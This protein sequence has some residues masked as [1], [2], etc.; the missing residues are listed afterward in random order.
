GGKSGIFIPDIVS[1]RKSSSSDSSALLCVQGSSGIRGVCCYG[2]AGIGG[3]SRL[4]T[5]LID[6]VLCRVEA[7]S[8]EFTVGSPL[9]KTDSVV[10]QLGTEL[11]KSGI[12][13]VARSIGRGIVVVTIL[14]STV[15]GVGC[16]I[17]SVVCMDSGS[18]VI[19]D[20]VEVKT[21]SV[22]FLMSN[23]TPHKPSS[24]H[25]QQYSSQPPLEETLAIL[26][27]ISP[28][29]PRGYKEKEL[30][31]KQQKLQQ[32]AGLMDVIERFHEIM[33]PIIEEEKKRP[34]TMLPGQYKHYPNKD[35][36]LFFNTPKNYRPT[37]IPR[38]KDLG[39]PEEQWE[40]FDGDGIIHPRIIKRQQWSG[41]IHQHKPQIYQSIPEAVIGLITFAAQQIVES[42]T[43]SEDQ[44]QLT[45][46]I[47][48]IVADG[49]DD[50]EDNDQ[51]EH[52][53][54]PKHFT[55]GNDGLR[56]NDSGTQLQATINGEANPEIN[57]TKIFTITPIH[58]VN[59]S[60]GLGGNDCGTQLQAATN[61]NGHG[62]HQAIDNTGNEDKNE[63]ANDNRIG[64]QQQNNQGSNNEIQHQQDSENNKPE[65]IESP[66]TTH[67]EQELR[68]LNISQ[69]KGEP[70]L[71]TTPPELGQLKGKVVVLK[72]KIQQA[73][74]HD[75]RRKTGQLK[76]IPN[77]SLGSPEARANSDTLN[78]ITPQQER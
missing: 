68:N 64:G 20:S 46:Q 70:P 52:V 75:T 61:V 34:S 35:G 2:Y 43:E 26:R 22:G 56:K 77:K 31:P 12:E 17:G 11:V 54:E 50:N 14:I 6:V 18:T 38:P 3:I 16:K 42:E 49:T 53:I 67:S 30:E 69:P 39:L 51:S 60:D 62:N 8:F 10:G 41:W 47:E 57:I 36:P 23:N 24:P 7:R 32:Y 1:S 44:E 74:E 76:S 73:N 65:E 21:Q 48:R 59:G 55:N 4:Y 19:I 71:I 28:G 9:V 66:H 27:T 72:Q 58:N 5:P 13:Q 29:D 15:E 63:Q 25:P 78:H 40:Q 37:P 33:K 45:D